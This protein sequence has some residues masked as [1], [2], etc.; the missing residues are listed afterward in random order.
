[1]RNQ[2]GIVRVLVSPTCRL[3]HWFDTTHD[4]T[5]VVVLSVRHF[6]PK[7]YPSTSKRCVVQLETPTSNHVAAFQ[8]AHNRSD[9]F[10][11]QSPAPPR[12]GSKED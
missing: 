6:P 12:D 10:H 11:F 1:M 3:F 7:I 2:L 5:G 9:K 8:G 4:E